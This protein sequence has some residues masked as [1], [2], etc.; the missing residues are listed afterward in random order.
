MTAGSYVKTVFSSVTNCQTVF[1]S[2]C[3]TFT[4]SP[5]MNESSCCFASLPGIGG[6]GVLDFRHFIKCVVIPPCFIY[7]F[8][9]F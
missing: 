3:T 7:L 2:G 1:Q 6:G 8:I 5:A 4:F 9:Y